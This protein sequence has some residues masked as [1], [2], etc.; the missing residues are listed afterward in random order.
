MVTLPQENIDPEYIRKI[1]IAENELIAER[2]RVLEKD[3][4][5][6][7]AE[8]Q[9]ILEKQMKSDPYKTHGVRIDGP[10]ETRERTFR[11]D[12]LDEAKAVVTR[13]RTQQYAPPD[14]DFKNIAGLWS[15][16]LGCSV[17]SVQVALCMD[18]LK[19]AR[20]INNPNHID[21]WVDKAGYAACGFE[22]SQLSLEG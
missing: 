12:L 14:Q 1:T 6:M 8:K 3:R 20:L 10:G 11:E 18:A 2:E 17:S 16:I 7:I 22:I 15:V 5:A 4:Q 13:S 19:T 9:A 21:S